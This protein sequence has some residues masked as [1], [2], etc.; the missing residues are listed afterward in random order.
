MQWE[1]RVITTRPWE[2]IS[3]LKTSNPVERWLNILSQ[4]IWPGNQHLN[5]GYLSRW[6]SATALLQLGRRHQQ[7]NGQSPR[8]VF[9]IL[10]NREKAP[11]CFEKIGC[12]LIFDVKMEN[13]QF[14]RKMVGNGN[15]TGTLASLTYATVVSR[16][17][18]RIALTLTAL[19]DLQVKTCDI[20]NAYLTAPTLEN[21]SQNSDQSLVLMQGRLAL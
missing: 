3:Q 1:I 12:H 5:G 21:Y 6:T 10:A 13:F 19:N 18:V 8:C 4:W 2:K 16:E 14:K 9:K 17:S 7:R 20:K 15:E 11:V